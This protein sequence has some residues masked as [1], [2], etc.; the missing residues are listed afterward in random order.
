MLLPFWPRL[1]Y[2]LQD[3]APFLLLLFI[4]L[5]I[6][7]F[8]SFKIYKSQFPQKKKRFLVALAFTCFI[9]VLTFSIFEGYFR[10]VYDDSDGLG[11]LKV[12]ER[13][14][15]RHVVFNNFF[16]RDRDFTEEK[17]K[18][19]LRIGVLGDSIAQGDGI[20]DVNNRFSNL[21][22]KK[23]HETGFNVEVYNLGKAGYDTETEIEVYNNIKHLNFDLIIWEYFI[24]DI[25]PKDQSTGTPIIAQN[26]H[27]AKLLEFISNR[28]FFLDFL[29][30]RFSAV[31]DK[32]IVA[33]RNADVNQ[34]NNQFI[35]AQHKKDITDFIA[36]L[37]KENKKVIVIMFPSI[38]LLGYSYPVF[39]NE[40]MF[41]HF[42][43]SGVEVINLYDFLKDQNPKGL[44]ASRF[45]THPNE[46]VHIL[47][48]DKLFEK[49]KTLLENK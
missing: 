20:K 1:S 11:F 16:F 47:A 43:E 33:L 41:N 10:Y 37:K 45:D 5:V 48:A 44:R 36:S 8:A 9:S 21:L 26:S 17:K 14:H 27:R 32:T 28:S 19:V 12:N 15:K 31:Y 7:I 42:S 34:Y 49:V 46:K 22:E 6:F 24:N 30:W 39:T 13:W 3:F 18:D 29:Y 2:F 38:S 40:I 35:L 4:T 25:Q 23:L